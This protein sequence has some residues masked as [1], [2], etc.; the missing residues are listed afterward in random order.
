MTDGTQRRATPSAPHRRSLTPGRETAA[1]PTAASPS[2]PASPARPANAS[3]ARTPSAAQGARTAPSPARAARRVPGSV[4]PAQRRPQQ[5]VAAAAR[6]SAVAHPSSA[7][8]RRR[9]RRTGWLRGLAALLV[10]LIAVVAFL[11]RSVDQRMHRID[12]LSGA[13]GTPGTTYLIVGSDSRDGWDDD[14]TEGARTD[15]IMVL[16]HPASGPAALISIPRDSYVEIPGRSANKINAAFAYGGAPLLIQTVEQ[17]TGLTIDH[18][19]EVGFGG[20]SGVVDALGGVELCYDRDVNDPYSGMVWTAGCHLTAGW[21][22]L[23][24]SRMR[25]EDPLGDIGRVQ[26]QQQVVSAVA[27]GVLD[28][29]TLFNP[30]KALRV[31]NAGAD[32]LTVSE[33]T[34][35]FD[36]ARMALAFREARGEGGITGTPPIASIDHRVNGVGSTVLLDP[37]KSPTFWRQIGDGNHP[38][39][40]VGGY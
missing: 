24:F 12:V 16:H 39:G 4:P 21:D 1:R 6:R 3:P 25:Y 32:S 37:E 19:V 31:A 23:A 36:I 13:P 40:V 35:A 26:R 9:R 34:H 5:D 27:N 11:Y 7:P 20:V 8:A 30:S 14:G 33:G 10:V 22:A 2:R 29:G 38:A 18:Y 28:P 15:T 17:L